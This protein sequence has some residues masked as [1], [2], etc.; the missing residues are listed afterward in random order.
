[1]EYRRQRQSRER[2]EF[3]RAS[4][5][6]PVRLLVEAECTAQAR[7][8][9]D[10]RDTQ[11]LLVEQLRK[12]LDAVKAREQRLQQRLRELEAIHKADVALLLEES[13]RTSNALLCIR[14][15]CDYQQT[16][17]RDESPCAGDLLAALISEAGVSEACASGVGGLDEADERTIYH[18]VVGV[19]VD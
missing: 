3:F 6:T 17:E 16:S 9:E 14:G 11:V 15:L 13:Q 10:E 5:N 7:V 18:E 4:S 19:V 2:D 8:L 1:M 12:E